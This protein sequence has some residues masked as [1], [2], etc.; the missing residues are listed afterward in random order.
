MCGHL[1]SVWSVC[2]SVHSYPHLLLPHKS[3][4]LHKIILL[5]PPATY[6]PIGP[7]DD[8]Q[9]TR[10]A[11]HVYWW[12][13]AWLVGPN[14]SPKVGHVISNMFLLVHFWLRAALVIRLLSN[15]VRGEG[16][17]GPREQHNTDKRRRLL[18]PYGFCGLKRPAMMVMMVI[19]HDAKL[20]HPKTITYRVWFGYSDEFTEKAY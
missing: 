19:W 14:R 8:R 16:P 1:K 5:S 3:A 6:G 17:E 18:L 20:S 9:T 7:A 10:T 11:S 12:W 13:I 2:L 15:V 4:L